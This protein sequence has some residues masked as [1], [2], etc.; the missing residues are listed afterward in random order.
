MPDEHAPILIV[1]NPKAGG[2]LAG[3]LVPYLA[4]DLG[5][6]GYP[7]EVFQSSAAGQITQHVRAISE[8]LRALTVIG[9]DGTVREVLAGEPGP[10]LPIA[11]L[12]AG[13]ANVLAAE[14]RLPKSPRDTAQMIDARH[15]RVI[16]LGLLRRPHMPDEPFAL[17]VGAGADARIVHKVHA[18]RGSGTLGKLRYIGPIFG[19]L[20]QYK[21]VAHWFVLE[22]GSRV[23]PFEQVLVTNVTSY[24]GMWKLPGPIRTDD[25]LLDCIG[26]R[27]KNGRE[28]LK[29]GVL[30]MLN[31]LHEGDDVVHLQAARVR[32]E[33]EADSPVQVDGDPLGECPFEVVVRPRAVRLAVPRPTRDDKD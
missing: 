17:F 15:T 10:D 5:R 11:V 28:L 26:F 23:G 24:G 18:K 29:Q 12:P 30:G 9:G 22:D 33:A 6:L 4:R 8:P 7:V 19:A 21:A 27:A 1:V 31:K 20:L 2:G 14:L 32:V 13:T 25:G 16:D 3:E